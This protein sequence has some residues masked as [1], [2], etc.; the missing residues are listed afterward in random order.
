[1]NIVLFNNDLRISDHQPLTEA[2]RAGEVLPVYVFEPS[3]WKET[4]LSARHFQFVVESLE[5]LSQSIE[6]KGGKLLVAIDELETVL[7]KLL[8]TYDS[9]NLFAHNDNRLKD[10]VGGWAKQNQQLL[11]SFGSDL[12][13]ISV[14]LFNNRLNSYL[15][16]PIAEVPNRIDVPSKIPDFLFADFKKLNNFRVKGSKIRFGQQ[17]GEMKAIETL[18]SFLEGRFTNY[19]ENQQKPLPSS[20]SSSR[21]SAYITWGNISVRTIYQKTDEKL[22]ACELEEDKIQLAEFLSKL[23]ARVNIC[24]MKIEHQQLGDV[25]EIKREWNEEWFQRWLQGR[26][27]IPIIDAA[28]RS[29][30]KTGWMN[31]SLRA[32]VT[33]FF[34]NTL[35]LD[36]QKLSA[37]LA[38]LYLDYEPAVHDFY[39][40]QQSGMKGKMKIID[41]VKIG[42][43]LDPDGT[44]IRRYI[45]ELSKL[46]DG[47]I[48]EPWL[49]PA[50][51]QLG[52]EAPMVDV[53]KAYKNARLQHQAIEKKGKS[54][55]KKEEGQTEQLSFDI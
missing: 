10:K 14:K 7:G 31:F 13:N 5:E 47:Y 45:P 48:H 25:R 37:A 27:G 50:F 36:E 24:S 17:G 3:Q 8:D 11:F 22:Q 29:L 33:S 34:A 9:I 6:E 23:T 12:E 53:K 49:Y 21:L 20:L 16:E 39:I 46:P 15:K 44:F 41:P 30:D 26:T 42:R 43:Q 38:E 19:I 1:M 4:P 35:L 52:Y 55:R 32:M 54:G 2:A 28:M 18:D 51:Y 40:Q